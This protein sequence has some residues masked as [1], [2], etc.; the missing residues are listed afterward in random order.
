MYLY[1][2][3]VRKEKFGKSCFALPTPCRTVHQGR[4]LLL[5]L[6]PLA[7]RPPHRLCGW[8]ENNAFVL[9]GLEDFTSSL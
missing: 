6:L 2:S 1:A 8:T 5:G 9:L 7:V 3:V 4:Q